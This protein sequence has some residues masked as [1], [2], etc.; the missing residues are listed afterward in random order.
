[1]R[2]RRTAQINACRRPQQ[3]HGAQIVGGCAARGTQRL[4]LRRLATGGGCGTAEHAQRRRG[5]Q[6]RTPTGR[7]GCRGTAHRVARREGRRDGAQCGDAAVAA[8][9]AGRQG[10]CVTVRQ[11]RV[12]G[13]DEMMLMLVLML[14]AAAC[15]AIACRSTPTIG[16]AN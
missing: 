12:G 6:L 8:A 1:M 5:A 15:A 14:I 13:R 16:S 9:Y 2:Q 11:R 10:V 3:L 7:G 4:G